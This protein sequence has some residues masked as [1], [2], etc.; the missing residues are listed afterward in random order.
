MIT[1]NCEVDNPNDGLN[2]LI[3]S[4]PSETLDIDHVNDGPGDTTS[5]DVNGVNFVSTVISSDNTEEITNASLT[6]VASSFLDKAVVICTNAE[7]IM[8]NCTLF[9]KSKY[10][11]C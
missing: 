7:N 6:F 11:A 10:E 1:I 2:V 9:I 8:N 5:D 4:N 3:W